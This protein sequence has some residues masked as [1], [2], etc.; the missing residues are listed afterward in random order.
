MAVIETKD[1]VLVVPL[2]KAQKVK[3]MVRILKGRG[4]L[5]HQREV[6]RPW[7]SYKY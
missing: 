6:Y 2:A 3:D 4:E 7:G 5:D 1:C